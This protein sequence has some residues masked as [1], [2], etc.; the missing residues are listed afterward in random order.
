M[1][2]RGLLLGPTRRLTNVA[3]RLLRVVSSTQMR[4]LASVPDALFDPPAMAVDPVPRTIEVDDACLARESLQRPDRDTESSTREF[5]DAF[6]KWNGTAAAFAFSAGRV[7]LSACIHALGLEPGDEAIV[8]GYTCV[9]VPNAFEFAGVRVVYADIELDTYGLDVESLARHVTPRTRAIVVQ[10]L[11]GLVCRDHDRIIEF[12]RARGI[13]VIEDCCHAT[14]ASYRDKR[15]GNA[16]DVAFFSSERSKVFNTIRGGI[17]V[18]NTPRFAERL[19]DF[20][21][22]A[23]RPAAAHTELLLRDVLLTYHLRSDPRRNWISRAALRVYGPAHLVSVSADEMAGRPPRD[24]VQRMSGAMA[25]I[26]LNQLRK[27]D[28]FNDI[29]RRW[30]A[31]WQQWC[32]K[33]GYRTPVVIPDSVPIYLRYPV[34]VEPS[35]KSSPEWARAQLNVEL[36]QWFV[37]NVHPAERPVEGCERAD[38]AVAGCVNFPCDVTLEDLPQ[39]MALAGVSPTEA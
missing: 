33:H 19:R 29:R 24:Y 28:R 7:A 36:G 16:G 22:K 15:V 3:R 39:T 5:M 6:A 17:A 14:G 9:V 8:P 34:L 23:P 20:Y 21:E 37:T 18:T 31:G 25:A 12:A 27:V 35:R 38:M 26:G 1:N 30:A 32:V 2:E 13:H 11:Y 10:H 4:L